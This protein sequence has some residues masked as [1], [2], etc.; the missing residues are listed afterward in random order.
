MVT[1]AAFS[2]AEKLA[3]HIKA[4]AEQLTFRIWASL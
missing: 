4:S 1:G 2:G 3:F